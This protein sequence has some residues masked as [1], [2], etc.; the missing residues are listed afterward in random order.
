MFDL[1]KW[2]EIWMTI[3]RNK[4]RSI[5]T[6]FGVFWGILMLT[7][8]LGTGNGLEN[9]MKSNIEGVATNSCFFY[10]DI[11]TVPFKG[12][13]KG[14][15]WNMKNS[16]IKVILANVPEIKY[17]APMLFG[18][19]GGQNNTVRGDKA[20]TF[21]VMGN[22]PDYAHVQEQKI[23][24]GRYINNVDILNKRKV[25]YIGNN[26]YKALFK[27]GE[28]PIGQ[29]IRS[30]G[31]Y[32]TVVGVGSGLGKIELGGKSD[33][34]V[35]LP[36]TTMQTAYNQ[37][38]IIHFMAAVA[39]D[40]VD[41]SYVEKEVKKILKARNDIS[42]TDERAVGSF[43]ISQIFKMFSYL[44][45]GIRILIWIVGLG[46]LIAGAIGVSNIMLVSVRERTKEIGIR[47]ALGAKPRDI[48][49]QI[50]NESLVLTA[51]AGFIGLSLGVGI[52]AYFDNYINNLPPEHKIFLQN[53]MI[54]FD[55]AISASVVL[56]II[57]L[58]AGLLPAWRAM[59]I[60]PIEALSEE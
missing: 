43:N 25:C 14:R 9:G 55:V 6:A 18:G 56:V 41:A 1:D 24:Y 11:T 49:S 13:K 39:K 15:S 3:S 50:I 31:I 60:K 37:G 53:I 5:F 4:T 21:N 52:L 46:T 29:V 27:P 10:A 45:L 26:I 33:D 59:Q 12:F 22:Y 36:F 16:D 42:P 51:I 58:L 20:G 23:I 40:N 54:K 48:M 35:V 34:Q 8:L 2:Q 47:R 7:L 44:F 57:G 19:G 28:N 38:D 32:Y 30:N 17:L